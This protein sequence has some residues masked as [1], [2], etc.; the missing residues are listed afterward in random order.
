MGRPRLGIGTYGKITRSEVGDGRWVARTRFRDFDGVTRQVKAH[1]RSGAKAEAA[2]KESLTRR[3]YAGGGAG[4]TPDSLVGK[5][6]DC[7]MA[8]VRES[9]RAPQ[10]VD[11]YERAIEKIVRP[12]LGSITIRECTTARVDAFLRAVPAVSS[13]RDAR[14]VLRQ[15]FSLAARYDLVPSNP[16]ADAYR[17]PASRSVPR[18]LTV[19]D[20]RELRARISRWQEEQRLGPKR[21]HDLVEIIDVMLGT[22]ARI[23]EVLALR[24]QDVSG[25]D[26]DSRV[27]VTICGTVVTANKRGCSRQDHPKTKAGYRSVTVPSF[28]VDA[29]RRQQQRQIPSKEGLIFPTR[30]GT[31][32][33]P[34]NVRTAWRQVRGDDYAWVRPHSFRKTVGTM[35][36]RELGV[37][38]ASAQLG[39]SG[40]AVT[41]RHYIERALEA[42]D[43]SSILEKL[44][45]TVP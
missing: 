41:E 12:A 4:L 20:V 35:V 28:T 14:V 1:G 39:H 13:A 11:Y 8:D 22:G 5:L 40:T 36:E 15:V 18:A 37:G 44:G 24:W 31:A 38:A 17:P 16:V 19:D 42:P 10:T 34:S 30:L 43:T 27:T 45:Q 7:W 23:G 25:L 32:R 33:W 29:L 2:L 6:L 9:D 21:A 3:Q 26:G